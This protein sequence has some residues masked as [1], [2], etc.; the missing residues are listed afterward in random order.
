[1]K[2]GD[3]MSILLQQKQLLKENKKLKKQLQKLK[4][5]N[6][7]IY[8]ILLKKWSK[9]TLICFIVITSLTYNINKF[10]IDKELELLKNENE[11][12]KEFLYSKELLFHSFPKGLKLFDNDKSQI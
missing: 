10:Y 3:K 7:N 1:M 4:K 11:L 5:N 2:E 12:I 8:Q 9:I 6:V